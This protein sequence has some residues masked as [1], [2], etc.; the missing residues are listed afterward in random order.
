[1][2][3][4]PL[5]FPKSEN[6]KVSYLGY[7]I[8]WSKTP[9]FSYKNTLIS[10]PSEYEVIA[11]NVDIEKLYNA[12]DSNSNSIKINNDNKFFK[13]K[14]KINRIDST[15]NKLDSKTLKKL[16]EKANLTEKE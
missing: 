11:E 8:E 1:L 5:Q 2:F 12:F 14:I 3:T 6:K 13:F 4:I 9:I 16:L 10:R 15:A 7:T